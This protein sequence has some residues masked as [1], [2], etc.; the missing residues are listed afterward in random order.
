MPDDTQ[1]Q[2][3]T[4][5]VKVVDNPQDVIDQVLGGGEQKGDKDVVHRDIEENKVIDSVNKV[6]SPKEEVVEKVPSELLTPPPSMP[7]PPPA[8]P[9]KQDIP[10]AFATPPVSTPEETV[11]PKP[12]MTPP[13]M[14]PISTA[15]PPVMPEGL[16]PQKMVKPKKSNKKKVI[17]VVAGVVLLL[18]TVVGGLVGYAYYTGNPAI[19][20]GIDGGYF[21]GGSGGGGGDID[22]PSGGGGSTGGGGGGG[23]TGDGGAGGGIDGGIFGGGGSQSGGGGGAGTG[24]GDGSSDDSGGGGGIDQ[25]DSKDELKSQCEQDGANWVDVGAS[26]NG[27]RYPFGTSPQNPPSEWC[28]D[29]SAGEYLCTRDF[30]RTEGALA[31]NNALV[32]DGS[33]ESKAVDLGDACSPSVLVGG[34][35]VG[36]Y[37]QSDG[38]SHNGAFVGCNGTQNC[39]CPDTSTPLGG[40]FTGG[41]VTCHNDYAN[42]SCGRDFNVTTGT[43]TTTTTTD[44]TTPTLA[45]T[46][47]T[48]DIAAPA[49]GDELVFTCTG[50]VS[51]EGATT[52]AYDFRY[53]R[54]AG[55]WFDLTATGANTSFTIALAGEYEVQCRACGTISN[56]SVCDPTWVGASQ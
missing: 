17:G 33:G 9:S 40:G 30:T 7:T 27:C 13:P 56:A 14:P 23:S 29:K 41:T 3:P 46:S 1:L 24:T 12:V 2:P 15:P 8:P 34:S 4:P 20:A 6:E 42:D 44:D 47:L 55:E 10:L 37:R 26:S 52:L 31:G 32:C 36:L 25:G 16:K 5:D 19:I 28:D 53:R 43:T 48:K 54:D 51:P 21:G 38:E 49:I 18:T 22:Q 35:C 45:C 39:F 11:P 50:A